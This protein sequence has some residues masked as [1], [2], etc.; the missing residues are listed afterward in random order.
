MSH[1]D[2]TIRGTC[3]LCGSLHL[4]SRLKLLDTPLANSFMDTAS[5]AKALNRFPLEVMQCTSCG[6]HQLSAVVDPHLMFEHYLYASG[7]SP[8]FVEHFKQLAE[9]LKKKG[10]RRVVEV[11]SNDGTLLHEMSERD[12]ACVGIEPAMNLVPKSTG[13]GVIR[14]FCNVPA[15]EQ[16]R[17]MLEPKADFWVACNVLAHVDAFGDTLR[18]LH[19]T[20]ARHG[21]F[22]VQYLSDSLKTGQFDNFY[23]EH[24]DY[25]RMHELVEQLH[26]YT[27]WRV[28][29]IEHVKTHGG[30]LRVWVQ[31]AD[32]NYLGTHYHDLL[33]EEEVFDTARTFQAMHGKID[34]CR[35]ELRAAIS[36]MSSVVAYGAP[37]KMTTL[38]SE[39]ALEP[40]IEYVVDDS[41]LKQGLFAPGSGLAVVSFEEF[42]AR[43]TPPDAVVLTAWNFKDSIV[44]KLRE[45][46]YGGAII[47]PFPKVEVLT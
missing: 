25:W 23:H 30:S 26:L 43:V 9:A 46:G 27:G 10:A 7:T 45:S 8:V 44:K 6:H 2:Y 39:L 20:G 37:A 38:F 15:C 17:D 35:H 47:V 18:A 19:H 24:L 14:S 28:T 16:A 21:V 5:E 40:H 31:S 11:A 13:L 32:A 4:A 12:I 42:K 3:R 34:R 33:P 29:D 22:E 1:T 41:P 36:K